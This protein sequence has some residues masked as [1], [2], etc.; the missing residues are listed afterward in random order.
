MANIDYEAYIAQMGA[1][2][3]DAKNRI[4]K[5]LEE[6]CEKDEALKTLYRPEKIDECY[7]FIKEVTRKVAKNGDSAT[8]DD[9]VVFK[10][11]RDF[12][13]EILPK[14]SEDAPEIK[15]VPEKKQEETEEEEIVD[16]SEADV[17]DVTEKIKQDAAADA[18]E[19]P[20]LQIEAVEEEKTV[21]DE[22]DFEVYGEKDDEPEEVPCNQEE[23]NTDNV[24][25]D[26]Q[27]YN[28][29]NIIDRA[30]RKL[31]EKELIK[32][33]R[34]VFTED[35]KS[36][37]YM[38]VCIVETVSDLSIGYSSNSSAKLSW[39]TRSVFEYRSIY[40]VPEGALV[41]GEYDG[42]ERKMFEKVNAAGPMRETDDE[43]Q[44]LLFGF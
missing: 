36:L 22:Y 44:G 32:G 29:G 11:A 14:S 17:S 35:P 25:L 7:N 15:K 37:L 28:A 4:K 33:Q 6:L 23:I 38:V 16:V 19:K 8:L 10:M 12:Y 3:T 42:N 2:E 13:L 40:A 1:I 27:P 31:L 30:G 18:E 5:Y 20:P 21:T 43:G 39:I 41:T 24:F 26:G 34:F 9:A